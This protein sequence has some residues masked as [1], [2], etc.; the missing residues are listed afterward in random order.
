MKL[1]AWSHTAGGHGGAPFKCTLTWL[2]PNTAPPRSSAQVSAC[3]QGRALLKGLRAFGGTGGPAVRLLGLA[4]CLPQD[5]ISQSLL[6][7]R[8]VRFEN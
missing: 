7:S 5:P 8:P 1:V 6:R 4:A 2:M 3:P